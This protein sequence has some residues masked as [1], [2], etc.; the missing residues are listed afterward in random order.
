VELTHAHARNVAV[1]VD[2]TPLLG[3]QIQSENMVV[4]FIGI[5]IEAAES[6]DLVVTNIGD[7]GIHETGRPLAHRGH[8]G[9]HVGVVCA[10]TRRV[11]TA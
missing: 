1:V 11:S 2:Q 7:G 8:N 6:V 10:A 9:R 4:D 3:L 5:L